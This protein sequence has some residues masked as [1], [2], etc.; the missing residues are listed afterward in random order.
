MET[1]W[2][3]NIAPGTSD[4]ELKAFVHK[5]RTRH[6]MHGDPARRGRRQP[7]RRRD[8]VHR[9]EVRYPREARLRLNGCTGK[10]A[11]SV[12]H[13]ADGR[14]LP[15]WLLNDADAQRR[16]RPLVVRAEGRHAQARNR[17]RARGR[18]RRPRSARGFPAR[19][20]ASRRHQRVGGAPHALHAA[21]AA[22][23][24]RLPRRQGDQRLRHGLVHARLL[25]LLQFEAADGRV[26]RP[27]HS[28]V[29][30]GRR[31]RNRAALR[32]AQRGRE[33]R[34]T[35]VAAGSP[36]APRARVENA[37]IPR[38]HRPLYQRRPPVR[39]A[40]F[41]SQDAG[42]DAVR[43]NLVAR[44][45]DTEPVERALR[46]FDETAVEVP[47]IPDRLAE[48]KEM[49]LRLD[50]LGVPFLNIHELFACRENAARVAEQGYGSGDGASDVLL[51]E[52]VAAADEAALS[53][54]LFALEN[55]ARL[56]VYYCSCRTQQ[57]ISRRG[58]QRR[59]RLTR[60]RT[61]RGFHDRARD[62]WRGGRPAVAFPPWSNGS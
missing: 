60:A 26:G 55:T 6:R 22:G 29:R 23:M 5:Y 13:D 39:R 32:P 47:V 35:H 41:R 48:M 61:A 49:V 11:R 7:S 57:D 51:W 18:R 34:R 52:P 36:A 59:L 62:R 21:P 38:P 33:R 46:Y 50:A 27:W 25:L 10:V 2:I 19:G 4:E 40:A 58:M 9:Q 14:D 28:P 45:F 53:L 17:C 30:A 54:L 20:P 3:A 56:S 37:A 31:F 15:D 24:S 16:R 43:F 1:L 42:L 12:A 8:G 44:E